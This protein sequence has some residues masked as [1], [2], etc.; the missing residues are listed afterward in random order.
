MTP[1]GTVWQ[2]R[3][4]EFEDLSYAYHI[5]HGRVMAT[6]KLLTTISPYQALHP[7]V[8]GEIGSGFNN[9]RG[10]Q[11]TPLEAGVLPTAPFID[12]N[13]T[14]FAWGVGAG[15]DYDVSQHTRVGAGY[16]FSDL[17]SASLGP[18]PAS[19]TNQTLSLSHIYA[20]QLRFQLTIL[21]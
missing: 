9:T 3:S 16:Q 5:S 18:T 20:N 1:K 14:S 8:S 17:G 2:F 21:V 4:P 15:L 7:Y 13:Q 6:T 19:L 10:Y 12:H 11:E